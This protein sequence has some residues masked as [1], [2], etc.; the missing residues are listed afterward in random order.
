MSVSSSVSTSSS[1]SSSSSDN[2][3]PMEC[4]NC[5]T[6]TTPLWRRNPEG[7]PLCNACGLFLN[8]MVKS[9]HFLSKQTSSRSATVCL[10]RVLTPWLP[11]M[12]AIRDN[13][14]SIYS[15]SLPQNIASNSGGS[16]SSFINHKPGHVGQDG[17][18]PLP[19][20]L[21]VLLVLV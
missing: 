1:S 13:R 9:D 15:S 10:T 6:R 19:G 7:Q 18:E 11:P 4:T 5:H 14:V 12:L 16:A 3:T 21:G 8:F 17:N 20:T 2:S